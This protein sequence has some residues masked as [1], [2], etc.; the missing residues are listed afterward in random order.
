MEEKKVRRLEGQK[1]GVRRTL[2]LKPLCVKKKSS[3]VERFYTLKIIF[4]SNLCIPEVDGPL[5]I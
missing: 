3:S 1:T 4:I 5:S 2:R